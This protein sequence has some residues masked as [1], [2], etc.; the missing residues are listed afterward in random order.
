M[1]DRQGDGV[2]VDAVPGVSRQA[3]YQLTSIKTR[4]PPE[5]SLSGHT[6][7]YVVT[8]ELTGIKWLQGVRREVIA[9]P[10]KKRRYDPVQPVNGPEPPSFVLQMRLQKPALDHPGDM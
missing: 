10:T 2:S 5:Q 9:S 3:K 4:M 8:D 7:V 6:H 1:D